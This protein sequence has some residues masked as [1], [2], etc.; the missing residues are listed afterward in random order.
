MLPHHHKPQL[1]FRLFGNKILLCQEPKQIIK[2]NEYKNDK[3][4][5][6]AVLYLRALTRNFSF[7][8]DLLKYQTSQTGRQ[9]DL[10]LDSQLPQTLN[11]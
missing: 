6:L 5:S 1:S 2:I 9:K 7:E 4:L 3:I 11:Y 8:K 10:S